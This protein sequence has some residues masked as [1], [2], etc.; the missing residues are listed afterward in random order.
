MKIVIGA[1]PWLRD[2]SLV[3]IPWREEVKNGD[4]GGGWKGKDG[5]RLRVGVMYTDEIVTPH[6]PVQRALREVVSKLESVE[7]LEVVRL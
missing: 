1:K 4:W 7:G 6:P 3:P 2:P 5:E